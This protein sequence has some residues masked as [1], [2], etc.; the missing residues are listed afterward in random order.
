M[1]LKI[2]AIRMLHSGVCVFLTGHVQFHLLRIHSCLSCLHGV[3]EKNSV[4]CC[5]LL[6]SLSSLFL[7]SFRVFFHVGS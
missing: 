4:L 2:R 1:S 6:L 7:F 3:N 5:L